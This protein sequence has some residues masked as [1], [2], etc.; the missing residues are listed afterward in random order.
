MKLLYSFAV[1][2]YMPKGLIFVISGPSGSGKTTL[3]KKLVRDS[4]LKA[5]LARAVSFTTRPRRTGE[6]DGRDYFF[7]CQKKFF[8]LRRQKKLLEWTKF[9]GYYYATV[10]ESFRR[11]LGLGKSI[12]LCLDQRGAFKIKRIYPRK[13]RLIFILPPSINTLHR[14]ITLR[15]GAHKDKQAKEISQR[16]DLADKEI[17]LARKYDYCIVNRNL[18]KAFRELKDIVNKEV[19]I[20][21]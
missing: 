18:N 14:R 17:R 13:T 10:K 12:I 6:K 2:I 3:A 7:V 20:R 16:L 11:T 8:A 4:R 5:K 9:L 21:R 1:L 19:T 15:A